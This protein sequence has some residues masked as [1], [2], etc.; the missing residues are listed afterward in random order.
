MKP[1][2]GMLYPVAA[3][4]DAYVPYTSISYDDGFVID[5]AINPVCPRLS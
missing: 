2:I 4:V 5:D 3:P 1:N